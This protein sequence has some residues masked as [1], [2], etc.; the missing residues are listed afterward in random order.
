MSSQSTFDAPET[1][2]VPKL[3]PAEVSA[4]TWA[5][6]PESLWVQRTLGFIRLA[7]MPDASVMDAFWT[8][9]V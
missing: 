8:V 1:V 5:G 6:L 3:V 4:K 9:P 2:Y 7:A